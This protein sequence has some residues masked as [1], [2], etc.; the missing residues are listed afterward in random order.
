M[1]AAD[2]LLIV[3]ASDRYRDG[4]GY[5]EVAGY[6][7]AVRRGSLI[8]VSG[9]TCAD[10]E[11]HLD[12][13]DQALACIRRAVAAV[14]ALG[15]RRDDIVRTRMFLAPGVDWQEAAAAHRALLGDVAPANTL[16]HVHSLV[17][18][19]LL[20]EVEL[21]AWVDEAAERVE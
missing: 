11:A 5:E 14:E 8:E 3:T 17:G 9:T 2:L 4:S 12:A 21:Q 1:A 15:G 16:V 13:H 19:H 7:R 6:S 10:E 18:R 20:V